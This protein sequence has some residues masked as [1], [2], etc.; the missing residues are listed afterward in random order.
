MAD[1]AD[2][3]LRDEIEPPHAGHVLIDDQKAEAVEVAALSRQAR[4]PR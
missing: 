1:V 3:N 4:P 2:R